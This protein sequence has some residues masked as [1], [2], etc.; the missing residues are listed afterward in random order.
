MYIIFLKWLIASFI[1]LLLISYSIVIYII[2]FDETLHVFFKDPI[3]GELILLAP[4]IG[5]A[6]ALTQWQL[7]RKN[8]YLS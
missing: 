2:G 1:V 7:K 4:S 6:I 8:K 5:M 3:H